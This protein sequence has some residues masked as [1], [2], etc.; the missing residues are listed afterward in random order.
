MQQLSPLP[1]TTGLSSLR[2]AVITCH[3]ETS[4]FCQDAL[5]ALGHQLCANSEGRRLVD[6]CRCEGPDLVLAELGPNDL[7][8]IDLAIE[9]WQER[10]T[11]FVGV[12]DPEDGFTP[13]PAKETPVFAYLVKPILVGHVAAA[14]AGAMH[15]F[16]RVRRLS[17]EVAELQQALAERKLIERAKGVIM[18][19]TGLGE[20]EAYSRLR[21]SASDRNRKLVEA[22]RTVVEAGEV[23]HQMEQGF[24]PRISS[25]GDHTHNHRGRG[26]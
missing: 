5:V 12:Y 3:P 26:I 24:F 15:N 21:K 11:P 9:V 4:R 17:E 6:Y 13:S 8:N 16:R 10:P 2:I 25:N 22:A 19:Y 23:F 1:S 7:D 20:D 14:I 18:K